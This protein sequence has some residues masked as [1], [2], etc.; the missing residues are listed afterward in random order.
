MLFPRDGR[1]GAHRGRQR[2][3]SFRGGIIARGS[4]ARARSRA[5]EIRSGEAAGG[6]S[7]AGKRR[8]RWHVPEEHRE[9]VSAGG[10]PA[11]SRPDAPGRSGAARCVR[12]TRGGRGSGRRRR[13]RGRAPLAM[14]V[15]ADNHVRSLERHHPRHDSSPIH[16]P[17]APGGRPAGRGHADV[18]LS[19]AALSARAAAV[20]PA[21]AGGAA[22]PQTRLNAV[23]FR[24]RRS[25][26]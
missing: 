10:R 21:P 26:A 12:G 7:A 14:F 20:R 13:P 16:T 3:T 22:R 24:P 2:P 8:V 18:D 25:V 17:P 4:G 9:N 23:G 11:L 6:V 19:G 15:R 1:P 5:A